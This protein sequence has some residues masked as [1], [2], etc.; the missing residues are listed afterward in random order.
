MACSHAH[1]RCDAGVHSVRLI[2]LFTDLSLLVMM[3]DP[4]LFA[5]LDALDGVMQAERLARRAMEW[6]EALAR[7]KQAIH[8]PRAV[9]DD[10]WARHRPEKNRYGTRNGRRVVVAHVFVRRDAPWWCDTDCHYCLC[11]GVL[12]RDHE[13]ELRG[14]D[15]IRRY[16]DNAMYYDLWQ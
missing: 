10:L 15:G 9:H 7:P 4:D 16:V 14:R 13:F 1:P 3:G 8:L 12:C 11:E 2:L 6:D 5:L